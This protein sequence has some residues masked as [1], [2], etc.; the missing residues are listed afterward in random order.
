MEPTIEKNLRYNYILGL[1]NG[2]FIGFAEAVAS[3]S[4][5]LALFVTQ[6]GGSSFL[7]GLLSAIYNGGW[8]IPQFLVAHRLQRLPLM[9]PVYAIA[10]FIR[11]LC[12]LL[13]ALA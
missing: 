1:L 11:I 5:I 4:L 8:F 9:R 12:W 7:V 3:P 13:I 10:A 2:A 6:L